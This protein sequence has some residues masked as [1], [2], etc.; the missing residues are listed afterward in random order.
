LGVLKAFFGFGVALRRELEDL[1]PLW[2]KG[3]VALEGTDSFGG[4][5]KLLAQSLSVR[6]GLL[7][8]L[9]SLLLSLLSFNGRLDGG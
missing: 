9:S 6:L 3:R 4:L 8:L 2:N 7:Q 5:V 1:D